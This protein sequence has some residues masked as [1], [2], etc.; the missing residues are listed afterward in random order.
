MPDLPDELAA[1]LHERASHAPG[2]A[3]PSDEVVRA[4]RRRQAFRAGAAVSGTALALVAVVGV[5]AA[6]VPDGRQALAPATPG[7][8]TPTR[9]PVVTTAPA[10]GERPSCVNGLHVGVAAGARF[11]KAAYV[12]GVGASCFL[13]DHPAGTPRHELVLRHTG[14]AVEWGAMPLDTRTL[15]TAV[16][17]DKPPLAAGSYELLCTIHP[18]MRAAVE[19]R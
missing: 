11:E 1:L 3:A 9:E 8:A 17:F 15:G 6:V 13:A 5:A 7:G 16:W 18:A 12:A 2:P 14:G 19:V 10:G 4:V